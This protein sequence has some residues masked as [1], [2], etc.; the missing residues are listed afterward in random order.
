MLLLASNSSAEIV[1]KAALTSVRIPLFNPASP[2]MA[3]KQLIEAIIT[4]R[5]KIKDTSVVVVADENCPP[6]LKEK[7]ALLAKNACKINKTRE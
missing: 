3:F 6:S 2:D 7:G 4:I 5:M 1:F